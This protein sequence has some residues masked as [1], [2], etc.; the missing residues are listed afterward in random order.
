MLLWPYL[1]D[2]AC[3]YASGDCDIRGLHFQA[4]DTHLLD[5]VQQ[6]STLVALGRPPGEACVIVC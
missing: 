5:A 1:V 4:S 6:H 3:V 2:G